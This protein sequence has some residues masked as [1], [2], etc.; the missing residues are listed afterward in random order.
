MERRASVRYA[1]DLETSWRVYGTRTGDWWTVSV[2]DISVAGIGLIS[3]FRLNSGTILVV[4]LQSTNQSFSR[5]L[6]ARV[7]RA[8][9]QS[10]GKWVI[11]CSFV[12]KL[13][14]DELQ[15]LL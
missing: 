1:C 14:D 10:D 3:N 12:R 9:V 8:T 11:G 15:A 6:L 7:S 4:K 2:Q 13:S 5:P